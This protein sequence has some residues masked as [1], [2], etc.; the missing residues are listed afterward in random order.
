MNESCKSNDVVTLATLKSNVVSHVRLESQ[1]SY[2]LMCDKQLDE[3][4]QLQKKLSIAE[5]KLMEYIKLKNNYSEY[6]VKPRL[7]TA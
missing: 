7:K 6:V 4:T 1:S 5:S 3:I 2:Q